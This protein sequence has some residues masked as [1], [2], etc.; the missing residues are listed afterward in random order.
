VTLSVLTQV[1]AAGD[2]WSQVATTVSG[3]AKPRAVS[4]NPVYCESTGKL[5]QRITDLVLESLSRDR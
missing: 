2:G 1:R 4:G 3:R 5:E